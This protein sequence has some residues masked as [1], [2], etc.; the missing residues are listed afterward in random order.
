MKLRSGK[1][2]SISWI[3]DESR[4]A[5]SIDIDDNQ[6]VYDLKEAILKKKPVALANDDADQLKPHSLEGRWLLSTFID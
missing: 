5:F 4:A 3:L 1:S 2:S 6:T